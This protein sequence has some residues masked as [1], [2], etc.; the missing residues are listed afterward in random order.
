[1]L[2]FMDFDGC[3]NSEEADK[4]G[5][6]VQ[7]SSLRSDLMDPE[8]VARL[9]RII[10]LT[11]AKVV[12]T[13]TWRCC[14][15]VEKMQSHLEIA[16]FKGEVVGLTPDLFGIVPQRTRGTE[17]QAWMDDNAFTG[18]FVIIDDEEEFGELDRFL[19][20]TSKETGLLEEHVDQAVKILRREND[21]A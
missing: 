20:R 11:G 9:N 18:N 13:S 7:V 21:Q 12:V 3:L 14:G 16:G 10:E 8:A 6:L 15:T 2:V 17:V 19:I 1:M 4:A 5:R